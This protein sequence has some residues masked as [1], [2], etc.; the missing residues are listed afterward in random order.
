[1]LESFLSETRFQSQTITDG[2]STC[3]YADIPEQF[4]SFA[5]HFAKLGIKRSDCLILECEN[6]VSSALVL[7]YLL[8]T[9]Y[10]FF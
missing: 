3:A 6:S 9:G 5:Q 4:A 1:M 10:S 2:Q 8:K 7:L